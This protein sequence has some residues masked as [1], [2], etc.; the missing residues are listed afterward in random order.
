MEKFAADMAASIEKLDL[1]TQS[2]EIKYSQN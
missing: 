2:L 1:L